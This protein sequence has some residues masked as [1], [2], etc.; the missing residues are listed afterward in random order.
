MGLILFYVWWI[1]SVT[2]LFC[3]LITIFEW[4]VPKVGNFIRKLK[5][6]KGGVL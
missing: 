5:K 4:F 2:V 3:I 6:L 1:F